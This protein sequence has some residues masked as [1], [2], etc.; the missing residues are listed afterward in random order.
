[1][2]KVSIDITD[3]DGKD[4]KSVVITDHDLSI[5]STIYNVGHLLKDLLNA[6]GYSPILVN[7]MFD[8]GG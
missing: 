2:I 3:I 4:C 5:E 6:V 7:E 1:M 8:I